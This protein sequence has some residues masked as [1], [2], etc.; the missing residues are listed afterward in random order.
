MNI[1][2]SESNPTF[3]LHL[4]E[5]TQIRANQRREDGR[6]TTW[7]SFQSN[8]ADVSIFLSPEQNAKLLHELTEVHADAYLLLEAK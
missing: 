6:V 1:H 7:I 3:S 8:G 2:R 4:D 5:D